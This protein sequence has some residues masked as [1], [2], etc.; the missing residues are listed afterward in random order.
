MQCFRPE[1]S[2]T[3]K[4][5]NKMKKVVFL[6]FFLSVSWSLLSQDQIEASDTLRKDALNIF[7]ETSMYTRKE[8]NFV[9]YVR[10][11][12][13]ADVYIISTSQITGASGR[14]YTYFLVGQRKF[15]GMRDTLTYASSPDDTDDQR[16]EGQVKA[17]K[18]GLM[19][20]VA[21][22]PLAK[23][24]DI[25]F[26]VPISDEVSTDR[27][28]NW[29]FRANIS[30]YING[31]KTFKAFDVY[32]G[33][34]ASKVTEDWKIDFDADM[35][36]GEDKFEIDDST[37]Y[38]SY[39][40]SK[41]FDALIVKSLNDHW[42][43]GGNAQIGSSSYRNHRLVYSIY[44]GIEYDIFPYSES[45][46]KQFR[47]LYSAGYSYHYYEDSTIYNKISEGLWG[48][49]LDLAV[50]VV[51]KW[52]SIDMSIGWSNYFHDWSKNNLSVWGSID[53]RIAKG[54]SI[55]FGGGGSIIHNQLSL[56]KGGASQE[57]ILLRRKELETQYSY[58]THFGLRYTFG[59]IYNNVVNPRFGGGGGRGIRIIM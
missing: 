48:Q 52:G 18:M 31:Q 39:N 3:T 26:S 58:F 25:R 29:V 32:G 57:E 22:T 27:W 56:V 16:R 15:E 49:S 41:S 54:L 45:T 24:M 12:K 59:S 30:G 6:L 11:I 17:L 2:T 43:V 55:N 14:E 42:S 5:A 51:Q 8:I 9:N 7:M 23:H 35:S 47:I 21:K 36:Y 13:D 1:D 33:L 20:Y 34:S 50:E 4:P 10:D 46:R 40:Q 38:S 37:T 19:R 28:N 53:L 44:P